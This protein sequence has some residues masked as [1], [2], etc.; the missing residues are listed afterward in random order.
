MSAFW[1]VVICVL[2]LFVLINVLYI[3]ALVFLVKRK[4]VVELV[5]SRFLRKT[6]WGKY[7]PQL[8]EGVERFNAH[9]KERVSIKSFDGLNLI[10]N[11][12]PCPQKSDKYVV[13]MHGYYSCGKI[14][15]GVAVDYNLELGFN[16]LI[17]DQRSNGESEGKYIGFGILERY[18]CKAWCE[19]L[20]NRFGDNIQIVLG[21]VSMGATTVLMASGL[22][23]PEQVKCI[24]ADSGFTS[25]LAELGHI[26]KELLHLPASLMV[27]GADIVCKWLAGY[28]I[29]ELTTADALRKTRKPIL[30]IHGKRDKLVP[31]RFSVENYE[32]C[33]SDK[34]LFLVEEGMHCTSFF[35][36][37]K[38]YKK[39]V[40]EFIE[41]YVQ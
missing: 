2:A 40:K 21:G 23:L 34:E 12:I 11:Y 31:Y 1:I 37:N 14:D 17:P 20:V 25:P 5:D 16:V 22:D 7:F 3:A 35:A 13:L 30:F 29:K 15:F 36:D 38:G 24:Y 18:D 33:N 32:D 27:F 41:T 4:S 10:A 19:Y 39:K 26:Q 6:E 8:A 9:Q 28:N